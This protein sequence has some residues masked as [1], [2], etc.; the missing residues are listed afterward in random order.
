MKIEKDVISVMDKW[1]IFIGLE[2]LEL[3]GSDIRGFL[4]MGMIFLLGQ[5][6]AF[7]IMAAFV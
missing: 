1:F 3:E 2:K 4:Y 7:L 5:S 6:F